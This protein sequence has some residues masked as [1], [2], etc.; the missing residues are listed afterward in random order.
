MIRA[1][2]EAPPFEVMIAS[3]GDARSAS[4]T[5]ARRDSRA[6]AGRHRRSASSRQALVLANSGKISEDS[7]TAAGQRRRRPRARSAPWHRWHRHA[8][9]RSQP[10][11]SRLRQRAAIR[12]TAARSTARAMVP[13]CQARSSI[14]KTRERGTSGGGRVALICT[15]WAVTAADFET[16][17]KPLVVKTAVCA[18][19]VRGS[20]WSRP[21]CRGPASPPPQGRCP[22]LPRRPGCR[23]TGRPACS[24]PCR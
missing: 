6:C 10:P 24:A 15:V 12:A 14:S 2:G 11:R 13:S 20:C 18:L 22:G 17:R 23:P 3:R 19:C 9:R 8:E 21:W 5:P 16:S 7:D 4:P 1:A